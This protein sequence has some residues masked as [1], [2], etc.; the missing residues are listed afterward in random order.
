MST[1]ARRMARRQN[2]TDNVYEGVCPH[3]GL[4]ASVVK[5]PGV[6]GFRTFHQAPICVGW[7]KKCEDVG[8]KR[9]METIDVE[10]YN[11]LVE[12]AEA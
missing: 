3:C 5:V 12:K 6:A 2:P 10:Q 7:T 11:E 8:G 1:F 4:L 9:E